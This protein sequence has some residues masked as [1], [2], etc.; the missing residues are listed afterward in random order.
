M[1]LSPPSSPDKFQRK[2]T[3]VK[4]RDS[5]KIGRYSND[6]S[7]G[8][9]ETSMSE[10]Y[11]PEKR[12]LEETLAILAQ[13]SA[14]ARKPLECRLLSAKEPFLNCEIIVYAQYTIDGIYRA[15]GVIVHGPPAIFG[16]VFV[17]IE[18]LRNSLT[19]YNNNVMKSFWMNSESKET[20]EESANPIPD[21][22]IL[23]ETTRDHIFQS[24]RDIQIHVLDQS[25]E[26]TNDVYTHSNSYDESSM[27]VLTPFRLFKI[28]FESMQKRSF[29]DP[30][31]TN[32]HVGDSV[33]S[34]SGTSASKSCFDI[35]ERWMSMPVPGK[36]KSCHTYWMRLF[37]EFEKLLLWTSSSEEANAI[38]CQTCDNISRGHKPFYKILEEQEDE[39]SC[40]P[41]PEEKAF[42]D[43]ILARAAQLMHPLD[44]PPSH[45]TDELLLRFFERRF[46]SNT[47]TQDPPLWAVID[48]VCTYTTSRNCTSKYKLVLTTY[49]EHKC[50]VLWVPWTLLAENP[51][52]RDAC[53]QFDA[54]CPKPL[55]T[56]Y[57]ESTNILEHGHLI[58]AFPQ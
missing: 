31:G 48:R 23:D 18:W 24:L 52:Y 44:V 58:S 7:Y 39:W 15:L 41:K 37:V 55:F 20:V 25:F 10:A 12:K 6:V 42:D 49:D 8:F 2:Q 50:Y 29:A 33:S 40:V 43:F 30:I 38:I 35:Y 3:R 9:A 19:I 1:S 57:Q 46:R 5:S 28:A 21:L 4:Y 11:A 16:C 17:G 22:P 27:I 26:I 51:V 53:A 32:T 56:S 14:F 36:S 34:V 47:W 13:E 45:W 54:E